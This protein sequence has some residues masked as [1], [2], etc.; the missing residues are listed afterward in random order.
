MH[1]KTMTKTNQLSEETRWRHKTTGHKVLLKYVR[2]YYVTY[3]QPNG[4]H[5]VQPHL[6]TR[7]GFLQCFE[8]INQE[9]KAL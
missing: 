2:Q 3:I 7:M 5:D 6:T 9:E 4:N 8:P 1:T